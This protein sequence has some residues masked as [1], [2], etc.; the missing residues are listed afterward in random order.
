MARSKWVK[1][2]EHRYRAGKRKCRRCKVVWNRPKGDRSSICPGCKGHCSRCNVLLTKEN[3]TS[4]SKKNGR[5]SCSACTAYLK[6]LGKAPSP[7]RNREYRLNVKYGITIIEYDAILKSQGGVCYICEQSPTGSRLAVDHEHVKNDKN[8]GGFARRK[9]VRGLLCWA[10]NISIAKF[11]DDPVRLRK[12][13]DYLKEW[14]AQKILKKEKL[15][16]KT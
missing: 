1:N 8:Y 5:Y 14:P 16:G 11:K 7:V 6:S 13:A 2:K 12:A 3:V 15:N 9:R 4:S 10:C